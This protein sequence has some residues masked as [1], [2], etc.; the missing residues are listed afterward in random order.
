VGANRSA[1]LPGSSARRGRVASHRGDLDR[2]T[3]T[4]IFHFWPAPLGG[5]SRG[6]R[7]AADHPLFSEPRY[8]LLTR[9][10]APEQEDGRV[11]GVI[12][13]RRALASVRHGPSHLTVTPGRVS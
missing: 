11:L 10:D 1:P 4:Q 13:R 7:T 5:G 12:K 6:V 2:T 9:H 8:R 3:C